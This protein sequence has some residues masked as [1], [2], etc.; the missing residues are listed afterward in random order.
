MRVCAYC[1]LEMTVDGCAETP[2]IIEGRTYRPIRF[3]EEL[4]SFRPNR[5]CGDCNALPGR[6]HHHGCDVE[7]CPACGGQCLGC[8]C[9]WAGEEH[10]TDEWIEELEERFLL[11]GPD[12]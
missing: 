4:S 3:G 6:V 10:L 1:R 7:Q 5:R 11:V 2:I 12:E 8:D 9:V